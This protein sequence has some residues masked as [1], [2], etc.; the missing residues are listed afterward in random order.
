MARNAKA[1][2]ALARDAAAMD[3][4]AR[5]PQAFEALARNANAFEAL[6]RN[7]QALQSAARE[8]QGLAAQLRNANAFDAQALGAFAQHSAAFSAMATQPQMFQAMARY[9]KVFEALGRHPQ[10]FEAMARNA[11]AFGAYAKNPQAFA[12]DARNPAGVAAMARNAQ[13][14]EALAAMP[15]DGN[16]ARNAQVFDAIWRANHAASTPWRP[17]RSCLRRRRTSSFANMAANATGVRSAA[18]D[19]R[20][21]RRRRV[22]AS[23]YV[24]RRPPPN[25]CEWP[26]QRQDDGV[27]GCQ[28]AG[29]RG[30][31]REPE[32]VRRR[33]PA[34][35]GCWRALR[36]MPG[37]SRRSAGTPT[38]RRL[39]LNPSF[40]A[41]L[42][43]RAFEASFRAQ[44][45]GD[46][47]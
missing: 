32:S 30:D 20:A 1:F 3:A 35:R 28:F 47:R 40:A 6:A 33:W 12:A 37:R 27:D 21:C 4:L 17:T 8:A 31:D 45:S 26:T 13:A 14:F 7:P 24:R 25:G 2:E 43:S 5:N 44:G 29:V 10:A 23:A 15:G 38:S 16:L 22:G 46:D 34:T 36:P 39:A 11:Q 18:R 42:Q 41:A 9:A 19:A